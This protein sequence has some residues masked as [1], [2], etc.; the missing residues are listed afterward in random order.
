MVFWA[1]FTTTDGLC[2]VR[3]VGAGDLGTKSGVMIACD[4]TGSSSNS[5][6]FMKFEEIGPSSEMPRCMVGL[7]F[8]M[9]DVGFTGDLFGARNDE[10]RRKLDVF[11]NFFG[12][13]GVFAVVIDFVMLDVGV[14]FS[15][16]DVAY[17]IVGENRSSSCRLADINGS[18]LSDSPLQSNTEHGG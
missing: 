12:L 18:Y 2:G 15:G 17:G 3:N 7:Y 14:S 4:F 16:V 6:G 8:G 5:S 10:V 1:R 9:Y 13:G 11:T